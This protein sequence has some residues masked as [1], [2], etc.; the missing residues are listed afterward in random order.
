MPPRSQ[1]ET[2]GGDVTNEEILGR[3]D[4]LI[5]EEHRLRSQGHGLDESDRERLQEAEAHL[6]Q[7]WDLLRRRDALR[8]AGQDPHAAGERGVDDVESYLQ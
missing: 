4:A 1:A 2:R 8:R 5:A 6:D 7:L 3:I